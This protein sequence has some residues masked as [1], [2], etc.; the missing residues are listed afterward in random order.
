MS[1]AEI[2]ID[3]YKQLEEVVRS[4][5][6][7]KDNDSI[8]FYLS[9]QIKYQRFKEEIKYCQDVRNLLSH[10]KKINNNFAVEPNDQMIEFIENL[11]ERIKRRTKCAD[12]QVKIN[13]VFWQTIDGN[14]KDTMSAMRKNL[15]THVPILE[16]GVV[17]GVFDENSIFNYLAD[18]GI[19]EIDSELSFKS[20][21]KY[22]SLEGREMEAFLFF[23]NDSYVE[24]LE[25]EIESYFK[26]DKRIGITFLT[27]NGKPKEKLLGIIT[28]WD[29]ISAS[30]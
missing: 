25:A 7:L 24:E 23:K 22:I 6:R 1:N 27:Q 3:K 10:K 16:N 21:E 8:S 20:I 17:I 26:K 2:F 18:E 11:I 13:N 5:Y 19:I 12:I 28:P 14:V 4:T 29:I 15:Y 9:G 30:E